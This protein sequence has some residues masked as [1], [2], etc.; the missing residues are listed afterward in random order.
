MMYNVNAIDP[1]HADQT[2]AQDA[3]APA[4]APAAAPAK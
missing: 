1:R 2:A 3:V 4:A